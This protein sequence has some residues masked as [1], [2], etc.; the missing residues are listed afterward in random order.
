MAKKKG[1]GRTRK[2]PAKRPTNAES[3]SGSNKRLK[4]ETFNDVK[5]EIAF[6]NKGN[7]SW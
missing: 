5:E 6:C 2:K 4:T 1:I 3:G 7:D